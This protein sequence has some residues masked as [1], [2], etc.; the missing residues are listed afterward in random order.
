[1]AMNGFASFAAS[2]SSLFFTMEYSVKIGLA[3][4]LLVVLALLWAVWKFFTT[5]FKYVIIGLVVAAIGA[6]LTWYRMQPPPRNP[7]FGKHAYLKDNGAYLGVVESQGDDNQR[8]EVW[9]IRPP[10]GHTLMYRKSRVDLK[11][12]YE[13]PPSPSPE[14]SPAANAPVKKGKKKRETGK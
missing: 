3:I 12:K 9:I 10:G 1:M 6:G 8:G 7:N 5:V 11:D 4:G 13:P 14:P 2:H